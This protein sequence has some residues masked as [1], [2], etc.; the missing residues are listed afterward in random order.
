MAIGLTT[1]ASLNFAELQKRITEMESDAFI[2]MT[3]L[4]G[5][6]VSGVNCNAHVYESVDDKS[7]PISRLFII[8]DGGSADND[9][10]VQ[11]YLKLNSSQEKRCEEM[12]YISGS[13]TKIAVVGYRQPAA[14]P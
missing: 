3:S 11:T 10:T 12:V 14:S 7:Q 1:K 13:L 2:R 8:P 4:K 5:E 9:P 6:T